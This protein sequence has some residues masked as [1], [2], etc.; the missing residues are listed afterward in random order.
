ML[1]VANEDSGCVSRGYEL[2]GVTPTATQRALTASMAKLI[3]V[4]VVRVETLPSCSSQ[5]AHVRDVIRK[6]VSDHPAF[7]TVV[8]LASEVASNSVLHSGSEFFGLAIARTATDDLRV[9]VID[10]GRG[11]LPFL[12][13]KAIDA[14]DGRGLYLVDSL[15]RRWGIIRQPGVGAAVWFDV[16]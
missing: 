2:P 1:M 12:R 5:I 7:D 13:D 16:R 15:A 8:L 14:E 11:G 3:G 10:E 6:S 9:A 4:Q